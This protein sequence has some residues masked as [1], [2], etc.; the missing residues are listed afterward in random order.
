[1]E[2]TAALQVSGAPSP[3]VRSVLLLA[4]ANLAGPGEVACVDAAL[5]VIRPLLLNHPCQRVNTGRHT[6]AGAAGV[7]HQ[8]PDPVEFECDLVVRGRPGR[9]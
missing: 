9:G 5:V 3:A 2:R 6:R 1:M 4:Q 7:G 8:A